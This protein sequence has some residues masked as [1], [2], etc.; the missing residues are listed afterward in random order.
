MLLTRA[1]GEAAIDAG[2]L[3]AALRA[4]DRR[5][6]ARAITLVESTREDHRAEAEELLA[7]VLPASG[8]SL[9]IGVSRAPGVG[10]S[11]FIE[12]FSLTVTRAGRP[13]AVLAS[14]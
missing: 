14:H 12:A 6:L 7:R 5:A 2:K 11:P 3:A 8:N 13:A 10:K 4:G 9:R 1:M